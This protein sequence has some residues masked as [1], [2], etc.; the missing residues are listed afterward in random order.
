MAN[1]T[2]DKL[3]KLS[4]TKAAL[5]SAI[6]GSG[7]T[8]GDVFSEYPTAIT[9]GKSA[10]AQEITDKGVETAATDTF[11]QMATNIGQIATGSIY[12]ETS[13][14]SEFALWLSDKAESD[15]FGVIVST[16]ND[17]D[18][19]VPLFSGLS[20]YN[21]QNFESFGSMNVIITLENFGMELKIGGVFGV[22]EESNFELG[23]LDAGNNEYL[24]SLYCDGGDVIIEDNTS[25]DFFY[26]TF[27]AIR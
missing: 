19:F 7:S 24:V 8:V 11:A 23:I 16:P 21:G 17:S 25:P 12:E 13:N 15:K 5:K 14:F 6:N 9:S 22:Y 18:C 10:I 1:T 2:A 4:S 27:F 3:A 26:I 20:W